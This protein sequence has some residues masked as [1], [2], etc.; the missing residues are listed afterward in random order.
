MNSALQDPTVQRIEL[1]DEITGNLNITRKVDLALNGLKVIGN[2]EINHNEA[3]TILIEAGTIQG[4]LTVNTPSATVIN[5]ANVTGTTSIQDVA[6]N[7]FDNSGKLH[8]LEVTDP[9]GARIINREA[10][11]IQ[12]FVINT[13]APIELSGTFETIELL[14]DSFITFAENTKL[15]ELK[16]DETVSVEVIKLASV[17]IKAAPPQMKE[18]ELK[19]DDAA[20]VKKVRGFIEEMKLYVSEKRLSEASVDEFYRLV[21]S[22]YQA[23]SVLSL[24][25]QRGTAIQKLYRDFYKVKDTY[26]VLVPIPE[27]LANIANEFKIKIEQATEREGA[28]V[29][30]PK[31]PEGIWFSFYAGQSVDEKY[32]IPARPSNEGEVR[33]VYATYTFSK[34]RIHVEKRG[35]FRIPAGTEA[36]TFE[37]MNPKDHVSLSDYTTNADFQLTGEI[38]PGIKHPFVLKV[39]EGKTVGDLL[40]SPVLAESSKNLKYYAFKRVDPSVLSEDDRM[41]FDRSFGASIN[42]I[43]LNEQLNDKNPNFVATKKGGFAFNEED[44][45]LEYKGEVSITEFREAF[46]VDYL[47]KNSDEEY[48][49]INFIQVLES[50]TKLERGYQLYSESKLGLEARF[51]IELTSTK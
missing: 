10:N 28:H 37:L 1:L 48:V 16:A 50:D 17:E 13:P 29:V 7:T 12:A 22:S 18:S 33:Y 3:G 51:S 36:I 15:D 44:A 49:H 14:Q 5:K 4:N 32:V 42:R 2:V 27:D 39:T 8:V 40:N 31:L 21:E 6:D 41:E 46:E 43:V 35:F 45:V 47:E 23:T 11:L 26:D 19:V 38:P 34:K 25:K 30:F 24:E 20:I 9:N